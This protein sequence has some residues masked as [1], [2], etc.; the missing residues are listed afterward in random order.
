MGPESVNIF[1][2]GEKRSGS[3]YWGWDTIF[4]ILDAGEETSQAMASIFI[5]YTR[6]AISGVDNG[7][8]ERVEVP[9]DHVADAS[10]DGVRLVCEGN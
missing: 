6:I 7:V 10:K 5:R 1:D 3:T 8:I 9:L 2:R 4:Q